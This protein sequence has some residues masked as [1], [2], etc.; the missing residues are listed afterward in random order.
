M[1]RNHDRG[2]RR[3]YG[4]RLEN[5]NHASSRVHRQTRVVSPSY[6]ERGLWDLRAG[7]LVYVPSFAHGKFKV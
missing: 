5:R 4:K 7:V 1:G 3:N 2:I 6:G